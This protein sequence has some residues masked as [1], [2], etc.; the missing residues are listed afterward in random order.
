MSQKTPIGLG[1]LTSK[2]CLKTQIIIDEQI[3]TFSSGPLMKLRTPSRRVKKKRS[4]YYR[5]ARRRTNLPG[6]PVRMA[7]NA[8]SILRCEVQDLPWP[9]KR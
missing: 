6:E 2:Q 1:G 3:S 9:A 5:L 7:A 4:W 8:R